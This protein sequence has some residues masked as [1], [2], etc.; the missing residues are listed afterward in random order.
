MYDH[1]NLADICSK[2]LRH[3]ATVLP[4][5][6]IYDQSGTVIDFSKYFICLPTFCLPLIKSYG[7]VRFIAQ[8]QK[9]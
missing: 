9:S 6:A 8:A 1:G 5:L 3:R 7:Y 2:D 4:F